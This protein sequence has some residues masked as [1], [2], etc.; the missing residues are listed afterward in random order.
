M[1]EPKKK[2]APAKKAT[3]K[4][5]PV[6]VAKPAAAKKSSARPG[7]AD[8][9]WSQEYE[10]EEVFVFTSSDGT[11]IGMTKLGPTRKPKPGKLARFER[12]NEN[13]SGGIKVLWYFIELVSTPA[14]LRLQE[15]LEEE[16]YSAMCRQWAEFAG[17][18]L[19]E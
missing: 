8:Y 14:S 15:E 3:S 11:T 13:G 9:D 5:G 17:I 18:E 12:E 16:D 10:G 19:G 7:D 2:A 6:E 1:A 4:A